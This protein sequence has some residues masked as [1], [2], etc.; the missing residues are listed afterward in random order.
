MNPLE[1]LKEL[2]IKPTN[3]ARKPIEIVIKGAQ[4]A[5]KGQMK[6][7]PINPKKQVNFQEKR[8]EEE[9][10]EEREQ[11]APVESTLKLNPVQTTI[12]FEEDKT[13]NREALLKRFAE[14]KLSKVSINPVVKS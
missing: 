4:I 14:S 12:A 3:D 8:P 2:Q 9:E 6:I 10:E 13:F 11:G 5:N 7:K 1:A